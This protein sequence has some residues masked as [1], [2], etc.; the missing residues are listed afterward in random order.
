MRYA[1]SL[2]PWDWSAIE[3][4]SG[5]ADR[6][7]EPPPMPVKSESDIRRD[8]WMGESKESVDSIE[9]ELDEFN[10]LLES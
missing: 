7:S 2:I 6:I 1:V 5:D 10:E 4:I 9:L 8:Y 3:E